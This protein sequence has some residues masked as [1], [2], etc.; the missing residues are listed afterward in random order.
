[1]AAFQ[2]PE[3][4]TEM[5]PAH[6]RMGTTSESTFRHCQHVDDLIGRL[7]GTTMA[8][9]MWRLPALVVLI[10]GGIAA[11]SIAFV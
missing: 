5:D 7:V 2:K 4:E 11:I 3:R 8:A 1:M 6:V 9:A 10:M